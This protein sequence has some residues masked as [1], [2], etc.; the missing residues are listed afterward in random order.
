MEEVVS[1]N[2]TR[3]TKFLKDL[4][5]AT[6]PKLRNRVQ[7]GSK[8]NAGATNN[9]LRHLEATG[10]RPTC[11]DDPPR[12]LSVDDGRRRRAHSEY[13]HRIEP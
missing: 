8:L 12:F 5:P 4:Q 1:S 7:M 13:L 9:A 10:D 6:H 3:S 11:Y 2:L